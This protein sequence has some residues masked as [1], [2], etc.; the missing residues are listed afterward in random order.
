MAS[1]V[2]DPNGRRRI[3]FVAPDESRKTIRLG[4]IDRK[5]AESI[6]RHVEALL[7]A[8]I[9]G[10]PT[11]PRYRDV[12]R[13][14]RR[15]AEGEAGAGRADRGGEDADREA[16][17]RRLARQPQGERP[18]G[19]VLAGLGTV[20]PRDEHHVRG[21]GTQR[22]SHTPTGKPT[23]A[24]CRRASCDRRR[25]TSGSVTHGSSSKTRCGSATSPTNPWR[26]VRQRMGDVSERRAYVSVADVVA[27]H[28]ALPERVVAATGCAGP[29]RRAADSVGGVLA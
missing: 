6:C 26:H 22:V 16:V 11:R 12:A 17:P 7:A 25:S 9:T 14:G 21:P 15:E 19:R 4:K 5:S 27:S 13:G 28:R 29:L 8:H 10:Q 18:R 24:R 2:N 20:R 1:V 23:A 3:L